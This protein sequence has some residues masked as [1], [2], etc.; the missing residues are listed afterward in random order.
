MK[1]ALTSIYVDDVDEAFRFYTDVLGFQ[2]QLRVPDADLAIVVSPEDPDGTAL[3]L[4]PNGNSIS[5]RYQR[6]LR[7]GGFPAIVFGV[8]DVRATYERLRSQGV[9]FSQE[10]VTTDAG[11][12]AVFDDTCGNLIQ[13]HQL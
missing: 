1:I 8:D 6:D 11:T 7:E 4:E 9:E 2:T 3:L 5:A 10:P 12:Q 13:I